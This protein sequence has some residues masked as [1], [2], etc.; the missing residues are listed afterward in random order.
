[1]FRRHRHQLTRFD[2]RLLWQFLECLEV[3]RS[4]SSSV[5]SFPSSSFQAGLA[6]VREGKTSGCTP[7]ARRPSWF[8]RERKVVWTGT[9]EYLFIKCNGNYRGLRASGPWTAK[10][11]PS[12]W[13]KRKGPSVKERETKKWIKKRRPENQHSW[14]IRR[15]YSAFV[16]KKK[17]KQP[18]YH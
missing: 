6:R 1:M 7:A 14:T 8:K 9:M 11:K 4:N 12:V 13:L 2:R 17:K 16:F 18:N 5:P 10:P 15:I 3:G